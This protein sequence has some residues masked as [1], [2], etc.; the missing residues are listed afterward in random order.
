MV[1]TSLPNSQDSCLNESL[2]S[3][4]SQIRPESAGAIDLFKGTPGHG[5]MTP[6]TSF[7]N[8]SSQEGLT[9]AQVDGNEREI[10]QNKIEP[11][12]APGAR[13]PRGPSKA[14]H[15]N[16]TGAPKRMADGEIKSPGYSLPTSPIDASQPGHSR[17]SSRTSRS[18]QIGEVYNHFLDTDAAILLTVTG[19]YPANC[20][21]ASHMQ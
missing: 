4:L 7:S 11:A 6:S 14:S 3:Q 17:N 8:N 2:N 13:R 5:T 21:H 19:S 1:A 10:M 9:R 18:S 12:H 20:V 15:I 16:R